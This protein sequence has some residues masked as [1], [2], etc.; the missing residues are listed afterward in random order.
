SGDQILT[1]HNRQALTDRIGPRL[2]RRR[3]GAPE[4]WDNYDSEESLNPMGVEV[5]EMEEP[6]PKEGELNEHITSSTSKVRVFWHKSYASASADLQTRRTNA[7][8][9]IHCR[10]FRGHFVD[11]CQCP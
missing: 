10:S 3:Y 9:S 4:R 6:L 11:H 1:S 7:L 2:S 8:Q 5:S